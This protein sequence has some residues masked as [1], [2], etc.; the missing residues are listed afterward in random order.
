MM[1][2]SCRA[3][4]SGFRQGISRQLQVIL[5]TKN[6]ETAGILEHLLGWYLHVLNKEKVNKGW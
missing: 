3:R 6:P 2:M 5:P 4:A 1:E